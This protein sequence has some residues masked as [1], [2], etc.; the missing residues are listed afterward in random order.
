MIQWMWE[1]TLKER[2]WQSF[3]LVQIE[4][5]WFDDSEGQMKVVGRV[6]LKDDTDWIKHRTAMKE[7][8][9]QRGTTGCTGTERVD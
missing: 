9:R 4:T 5:S 6:K 1:F 3:G 8:I 7:G 2:K